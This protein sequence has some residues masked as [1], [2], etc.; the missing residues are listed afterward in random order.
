LY[1][2][3]TICDF[4]I[5]QFLRNLQ[6]LEVVR[7]LVEVLLQKKFV[8]YLYLTCSRKK[9]NLWKKGRGGKIRHLH[10][11]S[12]SISIDIDLYRSID[13]DR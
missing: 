8:S 10:Y 2:Y 7:L 9:E 13:I 4:I 3:N 11:I 6:L 1:N 5:G 12:I